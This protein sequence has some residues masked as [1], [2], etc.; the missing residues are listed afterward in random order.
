MRLRIDAML[1]Y[2]LP[3]PVELLLQLE[4]AQMPDQLLIEDRLTVT[5]A[6]PMVPVTGIQEIGR[7]TWTGG[8]GRFVARYQA[9]VDIVRPAVDLA[10]LTAAPLAT[11]PGRVIH[12]LWPSRYVEAEDLKPFALDT[13]GPPGGAAVMAM[14][15]WTRKHIAYQ[16]GWSD[17]ATSA[18][19]TFLHRRGICRDFA[20]VMLGFARALDMPARM[21]SAYAWNIDPPD[22]HALVEVWLADEA[23]GGWYLVDPSGLAAPEGVVRIGVG[24]DATDISFMTVFGGSAELNAQTVAVERLD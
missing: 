24:R 11:I 20:H 12:F 2:T 19:D 13:F 23:G 4:A 16:P 15:E 7:R 9:T 17:E 22:F 1:D 3:E 14:A 6:T 21:V 18:R 5:T 8:E 10:A